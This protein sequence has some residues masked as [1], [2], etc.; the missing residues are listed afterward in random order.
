MKLATLIATAAAAGTLF[1]VLVPRWTGPVAGHQAGHRGSGQVQFD[2]KEP[3]VATMN[4]PPAPPPPG[5][6]GVDAAA[7]ADTRPATEVYHAVQVLTGTTAGEFMALQVALTQWVAPQQGCAFCHN[8]ADFASD[9]KPQKAAARTM[10]RMTRTIN[11]TWQNHVAP[12]GVTCYTC[13]RGQNVPA[14]AWYPRQGKPLGP[15]VARQEDW[16]ETAT[17]V[18]DFFPDNS[19]AEYLLQ[20]TPGRAQSYTALPTMGPANPEVVARLY[21]VMMQMSDDIGV[22]CGH[23]HN[24]RAFAD[25]SQSTPERWTG[26]TGIHLTQA[27]NNDFLLPLAFTIP[28]TRKVLAAG[29]LP[30][31]PAKDAGPQNGN[32]LAV[33]GTCHYGSPKPLP[34]INLLATFPALNGAEKKEAA[35]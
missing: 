26:L 6:W 10:L 11:A 32:A 23:C 2:N 35:R 8:G 29:Q 16:N 22:N 5:N 24:S 14:A 15:L 3:M 1:V 7:L 9:A 33:C 12:S 34:G 21:E 13:H 27:I 4:R 17:T 18:H 25:W 28:Q 31:T 30:T 20:D 19:Y